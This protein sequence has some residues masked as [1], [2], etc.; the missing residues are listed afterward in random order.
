LS[1]LKLFLARTL[2]LRTLHF[3]LTN[4][5]PKTLKV[6]PYLHTSS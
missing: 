1:S 2:I 6:D 3:G 4:S 5:M